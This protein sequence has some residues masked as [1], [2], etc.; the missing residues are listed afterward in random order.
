MR[1]KNSKPYIKEIGLNK[2]LM[3][4]NMN[5]IN[6]AERYLQRFPF[7]ITK[8]KILRRKLILTTQERT[9]ECVSSFFHT[10][11]FLP[12]NDHTHMCIAEL[13]SSLVL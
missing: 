1:D 3:R 11:C 5:I 10:S 4:S 7:F 8:K 6:M 2:L 13:D 12:S 9:G